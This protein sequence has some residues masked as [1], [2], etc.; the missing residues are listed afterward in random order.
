M[1]PDSG[2]NL[3]NRRS[4]RY[5]DL[6]ATAL[7]RELGGSRAAVNTIVKWTG[8][9]E[10]TARAWLGAVGGPQGQHLV[11]LMQHS[12]A[13]LDAVLTAAGRRSVLD[14]RRLSALLTELRRIGP[15]VEALLDAEPPGRH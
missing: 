5:A 9:G 14:H 3:P 4:V 2:R 7:R 12:D 8:V 15:L 10:R 11:N 13:V 1:I 6:V